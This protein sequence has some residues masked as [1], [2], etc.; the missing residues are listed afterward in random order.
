MLSQ[1]R[2]IASPYDLFTSLAESCNKLGIESQDVYGDFELEDSWLRKFEKEVRVNLGMED[3]LFMPSGVMAQMI[4]LKVHQE[5]VPTRHSFVCHFSSHL[6]LHEKNSFSDLLH[7]N[8]VIVPPNTSQAVQHPLTFL[9]VQ[10]F[11][12]QDPKPFCLV[13]E[14]PHREIG[15]KC[16]PIEDLILIS[17]YCR[18]HGIFL[19][20]DGARLWEVAAAYQ[21]PL[22]EICALFD[23]VYVSFY[24]GLGALTGAMLLGNSNFISQSRIWLRRFGGNL[25]TLMP[26]AVSCWTNYRE[27]VNSFHDRLN[28]LQQVTAA[29]S[30]SLSTEE[31]SS[32]IRFDPIVPEVSMIHIYI[33]VELK[34]I[35]IVLEAR[36]LTFKECGITCFTRLRGAGSYGAAKQEVYTELNMGPL[37]MAI[38]DRDWVRGWTVFA[39]KLK[40]LMAKVS[41][42]L[43]V[44]TD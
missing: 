28:R 5:K 39:A 8:A 4:A 34:N 15:G 13:V 6:L 19:H 3:G 35:P 32:L 21:R 30:Q 2:D 9:S 14:C 42:G 10:N 44:Q 12:H 1:A 20:M 22:Q 31:L 26:Y 7:L 41:E 24:K 43:P 33:N 23:S 18:K 38:E 36:D 11:L 29:I 40:T 16:T 37:N 17:E 25:Y 27:N